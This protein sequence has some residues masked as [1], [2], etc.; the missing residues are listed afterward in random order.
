MFSLQ[1]LAKIRNAKED[2]SILK[3]F[4]VLDKVSLQNTRQ[5]NDSKTIVDVSYLREDINKVDLHTDII[6]NSFP[7]KE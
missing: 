7:N 5:D 6:R 2:Q 4:D 1:N 3:F